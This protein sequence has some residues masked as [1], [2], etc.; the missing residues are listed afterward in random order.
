MSSTVSCSSAAHSVGAVMPS[1]ARIWAT[2][3]GWVMYGSPLRRSWSRGAARRPRR[4]ARRR[5]GRPWDASRAPCG[6]AA[7]G[8]GRRRLRRADRGGRSRAEPDRRG[9]RPASTGAGSGAAA[10]EARQQRLSAATVPTR[11]RLGPPPPRQL[12]ALAD[13]QCIDRFQ[14]RL[15]SGG[16]RASDR[17]Q[18]VRAGSAGAA[19]DAPAEERQLDQHAQPDDA[20]RRRGRTSWMV[21]AAVP[22]VASTS[23]TMSTRS[24]GWIVSCLDLQDAPRRTRGRT[25]RAAS[26]RAACPPCARARSRHRARRATGA[27]RMKPRASTPTTGPPAACRRPARRRARRSTAAKP[28][29]SASSGV[30][31]LNTTPGCGQSG[32][33]ADARSAGARESSGARRRSPAL[34]PLL[35]G[36]RGRCALLRAGVRPGGGLAV[37]GAGGRRP[38]SS[39][40]PSSVDV[41]V[42]HR[43]AGLG[44]RRPACLPGVPRRP[45]RP[46][47]GALDPPGERLHRRLP[48]LHLAEQRGRDED[49][50][51]RACGDADEQREREVLERAGAR[52]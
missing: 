23:S 43:G 39:P 36:L 8:P 6:T 30:M 37:V 28:S 35:A 17:Q 15:R 50:G 12:L 25:P 13:R 44:G 29:A 45:C 24:P 21:A 42:E 1:S 33:V 38:A 16:F 32:D 46:P 51:V 4:P 27:A 31:S 49:R 20:R 10:A 7:R 47:C 40:S 48:L 26:A 11:D 22:P 2:A 34:L 14:R 9:R 19:P 3:S 52:G 41:G 5:A 18:G